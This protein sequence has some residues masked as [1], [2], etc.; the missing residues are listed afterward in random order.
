MNIA[1]FSKLFAFS[2][3]AILIGA[4]SGDA[5]SSTD[6]D[7]NE[8]S[9]DEALKAKVTPGTFKL[10]SKAHVTPSTS[11]DLYTQ[12]DLKSAYYSTATL[13]EHV[14]WQGGM[15]CEIAVVPNKRTYRL[16]LD[17]TSCGSRI[18]TGSFTKSGERSEIKITDNRT[19]T[20]KDIVAAKVIVEEKK[21]GTTTK[22][23]SYDGGGSESAIWPSDAKTL[24]AQTRGGGFTPQPP[25]GSTCT[26]GATKYS[27]DVATKKVSWEVCE[28]I[29]WTTPMKPKSG[30]TTLS[31]SKYA[32]VVDA[33]GEVSISTDSICGAD[34]PLLTL[35]VTSPSEGTKTFTDDFYSCRGDGTY[36][37]NIEG[38]F[39]AFRDAVG[40]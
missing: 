31:T 16:K 22:K 18:Y 19:R 12:L 21:N 6:T 39:D 20:C 35:T 3:V 5:T 37:T 4:C 9:V 2:S 32:T 7:G 27:L 29:D 17:G 10:Y 33:I 40:H 23:Y 30:T 26:F 1:T 34:K 13:E 14:G 28:F 36:I 24:V 11:C 38:V 8:V 15:H 25:A